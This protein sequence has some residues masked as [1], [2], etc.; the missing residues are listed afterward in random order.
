[1]RAWFEIPHAAQR[2][3]LQ[4]CNFFSQQSTK[5]Y[6]RITFFY[7]KVRDFHFSVPF[8]LI[9]MVELLNSWLEY[10]NLTRFCFPVFHMLF[11]YT[12]NKKQWQKNEKQIKKS[13]LSTESVLVTDMWSK[14]FWLITAGS[15]PLYKRD[16]NWS[17]VYS[18]K[19]GVGYIFVQKR[20]KLVKLRSW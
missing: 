16:G 10:L 12:R 13:Y 9:E 11:V 1:M 18:S 2:E 14:K 15:P 8:S 3:L 17:S 7:Q 5:N 20:E 19:N 4:K 6:R